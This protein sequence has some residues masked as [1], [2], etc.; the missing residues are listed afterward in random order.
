MLPGGS[1]LYVG[2]EGPLPY[3]HK[4]NFKLFV[5]IRILA[6]IASS[7]CNFMHMYK[8]CNDEYQHTNYE[9]KTTNTNYYEMCSKKFIAKT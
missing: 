4:K 8:R 3:P 9:A 2:E 5:L 7:F 1:I 6:H